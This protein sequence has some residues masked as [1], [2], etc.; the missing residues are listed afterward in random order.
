MIPSPHD[1]GV[2]LNSCRRCRA[3][4]GP[5]CLL[6]RENPG[7]LMTCSVAAPLVKMVLWDLMPE[8]GSGPALCQAVHTIPQQLQHSVIMTYARHRH[9]TGVFCLQAAVPIIKALLFL[10]ALCSRPDLLCNHL[11]T[12]ELHLSANSYAHS[13]PANPLVGEFLLV[14]HERAAQIC[15]PHEMAAGP[16]PTPCST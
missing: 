14:L 4:A 15:T 16:I 7:A 11:G 10:T 8:C 5:Q 13:L 6:V 12:K 2:P 1:M 3:Q 9:E